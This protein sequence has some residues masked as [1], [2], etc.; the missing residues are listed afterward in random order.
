MHLNHLDLQVR[1]VQKTVRFFERFFGFSLSTS[2]NSPAIAILRGDQGFVLVLQ[3]RKTEDE[4][5][6]RDFHLGFLVDDVA[7]VERLH[8]ELVEAGEQVSDVATN[9]R[10]TMI[11]CR[12]DGFLVEVSCATRALLGRE[13]A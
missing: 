13:C 11:Y 8:R 12:H 6:P 9:A 3:R 4:T 5:Y 1:D 2:R 10:G 7:T